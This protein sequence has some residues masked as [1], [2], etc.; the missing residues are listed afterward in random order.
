MNP[1]HILLSG[2]HAATKTEARESLEDSEDGARLGS[3][4]HA[5]AQSDFARLRS[6]RLEESVFPIARDT[7]GKGIP[8]FGSGIEFRRSFIAIAIERMFVDRGSARV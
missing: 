3:E 5:G 7:D 8:G 4:D 1:R 6:A 2:S